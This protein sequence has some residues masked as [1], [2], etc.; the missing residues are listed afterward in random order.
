MFPADNADV[1][2]KILFR[3]IS[4]FGVLI[5]CEMLPQITQEAQMKYYSA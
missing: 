5:S 1:A 3:V 2:D 4:K